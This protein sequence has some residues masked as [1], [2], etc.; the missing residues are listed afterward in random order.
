M[1]DLVPVQRSATVPAGEWTL[2]VKQAEMLAMSDIIP[3]AYRRKPA[4]IISAALSGRTFG[5]DALTAMRNGHILEGEWRMKP[6]AQL[7]LVRARGHAVD[8]E[9]IQDG[10]LEEQGAIV[11]A[12]R[13]GQKDYVAR[14]LIRDAV[15]VGL[16][17]IKDGALWARSSSGKPLPWE[18][19]PLDMCQ[20]RAVGRA[21]HYQYGDIVGGVYSTAEIGVELDDEIL[22]AEVVD[23]APAGPVPLT[24][25]AMAKFVEACKTEGLTAAAVIRRAF[26]DA[27]PK[28]P[29]TYDDMP[30]LRDA[31]KAMVE[32][33]AAAAEVVE[34]EVVDDQ[35]EKRSRRNEPGTEGASEAV[36][37]AS[38]GQ[39]GL[40]KAA[41]ERM[42]YARD[43]QLLA[44]GQVIDRK[45][46]SH[47]EL[48]TDEA[49]KVLE[50][51]KTLEE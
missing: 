42:G 46:A 40:I 33:R 44:S 41:Y 14:F 45:I 11:T 2:M 6:E 36:R 5:W 3:N 48:T 43:D 22:E 10:P 34:A 15:R 25:E 7:G 37:P 1:T 49:G 27:E 31:F 8:I 29:V 16:V 39:V 21:C 26:P 18:Q 50:Y 20:W 23:R 12:H 17:R 47:N 35:E 24:G 28:E 51:L 4:N 38:K 30:A 9:V 19:Y 32:E 13:E